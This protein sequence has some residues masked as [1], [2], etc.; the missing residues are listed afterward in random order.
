[1]IQEQT[2]FG[3]AG[4]DRRQA[5]L[6]GSLAADGYTVYAFGFEKARLDARAQEVSLAELAEK[7]QAVIFPLPV[8]VDGAHLNAP[9]GR[10]PVA[11]GEETASLFL[12]KPVYGG[13][14]ERLAAIDPLWEQVPVFDYSHQEEFAVRNAIPTA[15]GAVEIAMHEFPGTLNGTRCLITGFGRIGKALAWMLRG[16][17]AQVTVSA[18]KPEDLAWISQLGYG[19]VHTREPGGGYPVVFN[20]IPALVFTRSVL[21]RLQ[22]GTLLIDLASAPGGVDREAA[23]KL[24]IRVIPALSLPGKVAPRA[25]GEIIKETIYHMMEE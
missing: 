25:A 10:Q 3:V 11:L 21:S 13:M 22:P 14:T 18:R 9:F 12:G 6:I 20:T 19:A 17:G 1:M 5:E 15:E 2:V 4:G 8:T 7:S 24:G 16:I 23:E